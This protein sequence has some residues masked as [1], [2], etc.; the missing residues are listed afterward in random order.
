[1]TL[2]TELPRLNTTISYGSL[3]GFQ[4]MYQHRHRKPSSQ[5]PL[6]SFYAT[7]NKSVGNRR[8]LQRLDQGKSVYENQASQ[9]NCVTFGLHRW[10]LAE[11]YTYRKMYRL[12]G[13][14]KGIRMM[15]GKQIQWRLSQSISTSILIFF[16]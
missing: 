4:T 1:M 6:I 8:Q 7:K 16:S 10:S 12:V 3:Y 15:N 11:L 2:Q 5:L 14:C 9:D 13:H